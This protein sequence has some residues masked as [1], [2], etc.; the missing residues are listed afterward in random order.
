VCSASLDHTEVATTF[1]A[2]EA[3]AV[4]IV[5]KPFGVGHPEHEQS[6]AKLV[7][8]I[9]LMSEIKVVKRW[10]ARRSDGSAAGVST[11]PFAPVSFQV[12][13]MGASTGGPPVLQT[14]LAGLP[15]NLSVP[16]LIVQHIAPGFLPG[17]VEWLGQTS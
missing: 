4:A 10:P 12:V 9:R 6:A 15:R 11:S 1:R 14:I 5:A 13:A 7:E 16:V 3:G 17:L 2:M 8:T